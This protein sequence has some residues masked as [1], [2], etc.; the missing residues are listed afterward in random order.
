M[1]GLSHE[2]KDELSRTAQQLVSNGKGIL[3]ADESTGTIKKRFDAISVENSE[4]NRVAYRDLLFSTKGLNEYIS[5]AILFEETLYQKNAQGTTM[6]ELLNSQ[7]IIPGIKVDKGLVAIP[8]TDDEKVTQGLDGL[9]NRCVE[10]YK[11]GARFAKWRAVF[12]IDVA[13]GKPSD[14]CIKENVHALARYA[15]ICQA[16]KLVAIVEPEILS[17]GTHSIQTCGRIT[18][19]VL[20]AQIR[21]LHQHGVFL[22]GCLLKPNMVTS[23]SDCLIRAS[24]EEV[25]L[26]TTAVLHRTIPP[27]FPGIMFLSGG[28]SEE[29][30]SLNLN[31][32]NLRGP[33]PYQM[34]FSFG[35]ALQAS[36]LKKWAGKAE[37][38]EAAKA[39]LL[40]RA[41]ANSDAV[42]GKYLGGA[43]GLMASTSNFERKYI[44]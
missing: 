13:K 25:G 40:E 20:S 9:E 8:G 37:N 17:D 16:N 14:L 6:V 7:G 23:G 32:I 11:A 39:I 5:G 21:A 43:G 10:Y 3:A 38:I 29:E 31:A 33:H 36:C 24:S 34:S 2:V 28:Q 44:Y 27:A 22:E 26:Y 4:T 18:E 35:R 15:A 1:I 42:R 30:A 19:S 41:K 12:T